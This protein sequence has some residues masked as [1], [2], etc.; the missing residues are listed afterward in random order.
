MPQRHYD[1]QDQRR[2]SNVFVLHKG[3]FGMRVFNCPK[4]VL[5]L[6]VVVVESS[7]RFADA[8]A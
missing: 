5:A 1:Q 4:T 3:F 6:A 8:T 7:P 2:R